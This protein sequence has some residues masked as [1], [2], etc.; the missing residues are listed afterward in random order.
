MRP[1][2][3]V[4]QSESLPK[5]QAQGDPNNGGEDFADGGVLPVPGSQDAAEEKK[6]SNDINKRAGNGAPN[7]DAAEDDRDGPLKEDFGGQ[8]DQSPDGDLPQKENG[9]IQAPESMK[10]QN[11][12]LV[13]AAEVEQQR[14]D[15]FDNHL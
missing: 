12:R 8:D 10:H 15:P 14:H 11:E 3:A 13:A 6:R 7:L 4:K 1:D 9:A 5:P 2:A